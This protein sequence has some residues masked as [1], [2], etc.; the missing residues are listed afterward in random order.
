MCTLVVGDNPNG[1]LFSQHRQ[2][3]GMQSRAD[4]SISNN[5]QTNSR[6]IEIGIGAYL[7]SYP[8]RQSGAGAADLDS[9]TGLPADVG[10]SGGQ[11]SY[12]ILIMTF[13]RRPKKKKGLVN[14]S[15]K[16]L[17]K[18]KNKKIYK[19]RDAHG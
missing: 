15:L 9:R 16:K 14:F 10:Q 11:P 5:M 12:L 1:G 3:G 19:S 8:P 7:Y 18:N 4:Q 17:M 2:T 6:S 13:L